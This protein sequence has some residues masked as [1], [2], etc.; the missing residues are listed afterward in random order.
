MMKKIK[1]FITTYLTTLFTMATTTM[2][3][4]IFFCC[5]I[6]PLIL[7]DM[8]GGWCFLLYF[9]SIPFLIAIVEVIDIKK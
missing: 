5:T 7:A 9:I 2:M 3:F 8:Y 6:L 4:A 1:E